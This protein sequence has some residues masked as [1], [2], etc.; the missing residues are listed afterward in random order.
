MCAMFQC[1]TCPNDYLNTCASCKSGYGI[2]GSGKCVACTNDLC[3][4]CS[5]DASACTACV[6]GYG[7]SGGS[8]IECAGSNCV[9]CPSDPNI[10][11]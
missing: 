11:T 1:A 7:A 5:S 9:A 3:F 8:C 10:C 2:D 4:T 6:N